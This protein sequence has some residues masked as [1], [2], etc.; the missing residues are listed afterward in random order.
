MG[1]NPYGSGKMA[2]LLVGAE[3]KVASGPSV[4]E[5]RVVYELDPVGTMY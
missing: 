1:S 3:R 2:E 4:A 5:A